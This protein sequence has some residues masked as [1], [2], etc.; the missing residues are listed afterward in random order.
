VLRES[1]KLTGTNLQ[2]LNGPSTALLQLFRRARGSASPIASSAEPTTHSFHYFCNAKSFFSPECA[3]DTSVSTREQ[4]T[5]TSG[6][7]RVNPSIISANI[8]LRK[9]QYH[10]NE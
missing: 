5:A 4:P 6:I 2:E 10:V 1:L 7:L 9:A 8:E 3:Q